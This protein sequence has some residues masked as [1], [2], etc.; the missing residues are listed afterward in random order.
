MRVSIT[1]QEAT[2]AIAHASVDPTRPHIN[3]VH[4]S[5]VEGKT[6]VEATD[7]S[8]LIRI[9]RKDEGPEKYSES[10]SPDHLKK[11]AKSIKGAA[12]NE[13]S[14]NWM[15]IALDPPDSAGVVATYSILQPLKDAD[16]HLLDDCNQVKVDTV[17]GT[18][19]KVDQVLKYPLEGKGYTSVWIDPEF[20]IRA[21]KALQALC[22]DKMIDPS[23][24]LRVKN[25]EEPIVLLGE[26]PEN[27]TRVQIVIM[28]VRH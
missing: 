25:A 7:G 11:A 10:L 13:N 24:E 9:E 19:P 16:L 20:L 17:P 1:K 6:R 14:P 8:T 27:G 15:V 21:G 28:V 12:A 23:V 5:R 22:T 4:V 2:A 18:F 26:H 3:S